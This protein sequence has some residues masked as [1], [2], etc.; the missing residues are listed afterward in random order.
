LYKA[1][2]A[3]PDVVSH[4][5]RCHL[6]GGGA[7]FGAAAELKPQNTQIRFILSF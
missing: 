4:Q 1:Q 6:L 7:V 5:F 2:S 3:Q